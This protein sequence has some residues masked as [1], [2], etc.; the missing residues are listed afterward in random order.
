MG[1]FFFSLLLLFCIFKWQFIIE[2]FGNRKWK[3]E[4]QENYDDNWG[5]N[6]IK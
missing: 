5:D 4:K 1:I 2:V 3:K 6:A